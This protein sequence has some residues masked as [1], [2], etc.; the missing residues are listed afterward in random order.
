MLCFSD[1]LKELAEFPGIEAR[2][3]PDE[4]LHITLEQGL[5]SDSRVPPTDEGSRHPEIG[6]DVVLS[7]LG[8]VGERRGQGTDDVTHLR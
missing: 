8:E 2:V 4:A 1:L 5:C 6:S 7:G 3:L